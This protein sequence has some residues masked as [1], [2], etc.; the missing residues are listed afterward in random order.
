LTRC[1]T[2]QVLREELLCIRVLFPLAFKVK[3]T[4]DNETNNDNT[5]RV[6][7]RGRPARTANQSKHVTLVLSQRTRC[8]VPSS[9]VTMNPSDIPIVRDGTF[10]SCLY[11]RLIIQNPHC[12]ITVLINAFR[13]SGYLWINGAYHHTLAISIFQ[14]ASSI[15]STMRCVRSRWRYGYRRVSYH[16]IKR[17][18]ELTY[19][20]GQDHCR[21]AL[22]PQN[23]GR[24]SNR[25]I[26]KACRRC[27]L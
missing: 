26:H 17:F 9:Q 23:D 19:S 13:R 5:G 8:A 18:L 2:I 24:R 20:I 21:N 14:K 27:V 10:L 22:S 4:I 7:R 16:L 6:G 1:Q 3:L 11:A 25:G 15:S 12:T